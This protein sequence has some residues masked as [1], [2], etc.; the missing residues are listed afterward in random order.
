VRFPLILLGILALAV[1][2]NQLG[3]WTQTRPEAV[4]PGS[5]ARVTLSVEVQGYLGPPEDAARALWAV[6]ETQLG[7]RTRIVS[8]AQVTG[9]ELSVVVSPAPGPTSTKRLRGCLDDA[10]IDRVRGDL[11]SVVVLDP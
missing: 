1:G 10:T 6:C 11:D 8:P 9:S 5:R 4:D 2:I 3:D 7:S